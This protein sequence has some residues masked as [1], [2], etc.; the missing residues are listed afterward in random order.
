MV[1]LCQQVAH[2]VFV[3]GIAYPVA[4]QSHL[5]H[6]L[7]GGDYWNLPGRING[8]SFINDAY[9]DTVYA[10]RDLEDNGG[11]SILYTVNLTDMDVPP[12]GIIGGGMV[13]NGLFLH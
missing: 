11:E 4:P 9:T 2:A 6:L 10:V 12:V 3:G 13:V 1:Q 5:Q 7:P 8:I